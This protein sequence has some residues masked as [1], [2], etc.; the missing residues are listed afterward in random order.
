MSTTLTPVSVPP[1]TRRRVSIAAMAAVLVALMLSLVSPVKAD[2]AMYF[3]N[4][5]RIG[6][7]TLDG[8]MITAWD[9]GIRLANGTY[10]YT[11]NWNVGS[12]LVARSPSSWSQTVTAESTLQRWDGRWVDVQ[13]RTFSGTVTGNGTLRIPSWTWSPTN[14]PNNR[15]GY[16]VNYVIVWNDAT[17][18]QLLAYTAVLP[19][20]LSD[21]KCQTKN[22]RC[23][24]F[25]DGVNF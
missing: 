16:R 10:F 9:L 22:L 18:G 11:K 1:P 20:A 12:F 19:N 24:A 5:G 6:Q 15:F 17:T 7:V 13:K 3:G 25:T 14:V 8:P 2:A 21:N 4:A 23:S